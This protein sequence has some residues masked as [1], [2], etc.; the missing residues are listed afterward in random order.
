MSWLGLCPKNETSGGKVLDRRTRKVVHRAATAFRLA[1]RTL[2]RSRT[3]LGSQ[4]RRLRTRLG[5]PKAITAM[6]NRLARLVY[7]MLRFGTEYVDK[8]HGLLRI[9]I[10]QQE[11][12]RLHKTTQRIGLQLVDP[13]RS[14]T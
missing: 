8:R 5:V 12:L 13:A 3:D 6:A 14:Q 1:A 2:L 10:R 7:R 11:I 4:Y 9:A